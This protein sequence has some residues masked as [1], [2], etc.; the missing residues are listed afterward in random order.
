M[1]EK[2]QFSIND[3]NK[4]YTLED[5]QRAYVAGFAKHCEL[6]NEGMYEVHWALAEEGFEN[7]VDAGYK[8]WRD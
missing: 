1:N 6:I 7:W 4:R 5:L 2:K 8:S 3:V